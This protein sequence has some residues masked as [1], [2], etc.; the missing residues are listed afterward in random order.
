MIPIS[1]EGVPKRFPLITLLLIGLLAYCFWEQL[2]IPDTHI[3]QF[4]SRYA[5]VPDLVT[6]WI[7]QGQ[8]IERIRHMQGILSSIFLHGSLGHLVMN[9]WM[10]WIFGTNAEALLSRTWLALIFIGAGLTGNVCQ[11][12]VNPSSTIPVLGASGAIS[13][14]MGVTMM[15]AP[16]AR[17][18]VLVPVFIYPLF[19]QVPALLFVGFWGY[20]QFTSGFESLDITKGNGE[21]LDPTAQSVQNIAWF[22]HC[23]GFIFGSVCALFAGRRLNVQPTIIT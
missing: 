2:H 10:L 16:W 15:K 1:T 18:R 8:K 3:R 22:C 19:L 21:Y 9:L 6:R 17:V 11:W 5:M 23:G 14:I 7:T 12:Y 13:G 4:I 20:I